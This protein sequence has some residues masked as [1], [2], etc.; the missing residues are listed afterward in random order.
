M[1]RIVSMTALLCVA[2]DILAAPPPQLRDA[3]QKWATPA[4]VSRFEFSLVD[5]NRDNRP[6][7]VVRI[8]D[9]DRCGSGGCVLLV[10]KGTPQGYEK[11]GN[12]GYVRKPI[13]VLKEAS[14]GWQSL[15]GVVGLGQGA[16]M[17]PIRYT[18]T[19]Y[20]SDPIMRRHMEMT[21]GN[22]EP[23]PLQFEAAE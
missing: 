19:E 7:A 1:N 17:R 20:R 9:D 6:D 23:T 11:I 5:L 2:T 22:H 15:A 16:G 8:T 14:S 3:V 4:S 12:S 18:G 13:F 10:F 21:A